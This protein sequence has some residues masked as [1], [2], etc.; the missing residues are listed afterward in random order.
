MKR[1]K[2]HDDFYYKRHQ[3][4]LPVIHATRNIGIYVDDSFSPDVSGAEN[5]AVSSMTRSSSIRM[6][7][8]TLCAAGHRVM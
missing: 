1:E 7:P 5:H 3:E 4:I 6:Q 8:I 2:I